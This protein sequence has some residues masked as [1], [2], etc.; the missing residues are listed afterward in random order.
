MLPRS[1]AAANMRLRIQAPASNLKCSANPISARS[2]SRQQI[3][4]QIR[5]HSIRQSSQHGTRASA[6]RQS[7]LQGCRIAG[8]SLGGAVPAMS[9]SVAASAASG[10]KTVLVPV[11]NGS[12]EIEAVSDLIACCPNPYAR[13]C[14][15]RC[16]NATL[17]NIVS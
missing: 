8:R 2:S 6:H 17:Q 11:G 15:V 3:Q 14:D 4:S 10:S 5:C 1:I 13:S 9:R 7:S 12:E 16:H